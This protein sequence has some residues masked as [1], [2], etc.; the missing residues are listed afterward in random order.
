MFF[1]PLHQFNA[2]SIQNDFGFV[3]SGSWWSKKVS[4]CF[5]NNHETESYQHLQQN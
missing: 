3:F 1:V 4:D 2:L 5:L